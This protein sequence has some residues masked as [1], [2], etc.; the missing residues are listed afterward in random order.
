MTNITTQSPPYTYSET[1]H[2]LLVM[3]E[4]IEVKSTSTTRSVQ[5]ITINGYKVDK[6][7]NM[8]SNSWSKLTESQRKE[9]TKKGSSIERP[10]LSHMSLGIIIIEP[11]GTRTRMDSQRVKFVG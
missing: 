11:L 6:N 3:S 2:K 10:I 1:L 5:N 4:K 8:D 9:F 7:L